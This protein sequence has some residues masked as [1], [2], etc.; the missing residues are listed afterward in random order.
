MEKLVYRRTYKNVPNSLIICVHKC[1]EKEVRDLFNPYLVYIDDVSEDKNSISLNKNDNSK[2]TTEFW[3]E[4]LT[5]LKNNG[6]NFTS[7]V[8]N[9]YE[10]YGKE[11]AKKKEREEI[12]KAEKQIKQNEEQLNNQDEGEYVLYCNK[13]GCTTDIIFCLKKCKYNTLHEMNCRPA[14]VK[15][16]KEGI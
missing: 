14:R 6:F 9:K 12:K 11:L 16:K 8:N 3:Y 1:F 7:C 2:S 10:Y 13:Y 5:T 15:I 4:V